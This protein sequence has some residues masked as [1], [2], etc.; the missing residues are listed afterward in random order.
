[1]EKPNLILIVLDSVRADH[2]GCY[3]YK[4][5]TTPFL[6]E[7]AEKGLKLEC[8]SN[9]Y[10]SVPSHASIFTGK[11]PSEHQTLAKKNSFFNEENRLVTSLQEKGY[12]TYGNTN[13]AWVN[14]LY[15][16]DRDFDKFDHQLWST[17]IQDD[18]LE[19]LIEELQSKDWDSR[20]EK[21]IHGIK[22]SLKLGPS[23]LGK[24]LAYKFERAYGKRFGIGDNGASQSLRKIREEL[25]NNE[26]PLL[27]FTNLMEAHAPYV[28]SLNFRR[29]F[30]SRYIP[31]DGIINAE[32]EVNEAELEERINLYDD[33]IRYLDSKL[34]EFVKDTRENNPDT[35]FII[36]SDHGELFFDNS[37]EIEEPKQGHR[38]PSSSREML[39][40]PLI[41]YGLDKYIENIQQG[42]FSLKELVNLS[43]AIAD[44]DSFKPE[45][46]VIA[47]NIF[48]KYESS[49]M[50]T[51]GENLAVKSETKE[52]IIGDQEK[53]KQLLKDLEE[54]TMPLERL[55]LKMKHTDELEDDIDF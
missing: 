52:K 45:E 26:K 29:K 19:E 36:T 7:I 30:S 33:C 40:V 6:D 4:R 13:N 27:A 9:A 2:V 12:F 43:N 37:I 15:G 10:W 53:G 35:V 3:G 50:C 31:K 39:K 18:R 49:K 14:E 23:S 42:L 20:K 48:H 38:E 1:M 54:N 16:F 51:D 41:V 24:L 22:E 5:D 55:K 17:D 21:Y 44:G 25:K 32:G 8:Y 34:E 47:E 46:T 11:L 28:P